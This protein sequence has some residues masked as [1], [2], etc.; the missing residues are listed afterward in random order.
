MILKPSP[1]LQKQCRHLEKV[2]IIPLEVR[3]RSQD[4]KLRVLW[5]CVRYLGCGPSPTCGTEVDHVSSSNVDGPVVEPAVTDLDQVS[6][7]DSTLKRQQPPCLLMV[8]FS[9][10]NLFTTSLEP[11][12]IQFRTSLE[13]EFR[14]SSE[15][16]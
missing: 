8:T 10:Q 12:Q 7:S 1:D 9:S 5:G 2:L 15:L 13:P 3:R 4:Q 16:V 14:S 6:G 11:V